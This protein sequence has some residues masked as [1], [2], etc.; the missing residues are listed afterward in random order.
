MVNE[1]ISKKKRIALL[2]TYFV[3]YLFVFQLL[4]EGAV[5]TKFG[6]T[7]LILSDALANAFVLVFFVYL[8]NDWLSKQWQIF[9]QKEQRSLRI[10]VY[11]F[12]A[13]LAVTILFS[14]CIA[15]PLH[16]S[17]AEN[18]V[19]NETMMGF[20]KIGFLFL[21]LM[22]APFVE[23][24]VFRGCIYHP[25]GQKWGMLA[26]ALLSGLIF[27]LLHIGASVSMGNWTNVL[28]IIDYGMCG[29]VLSY[30]FG[31][32]DSIWTSIIVHALFNLFGVLTML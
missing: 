17:E 15:G 20:N 5:Y 11:G 26:G 21:S 13:L 27:G 10:I 31:R 2:L 4:I 28:Y 29:V 14:L 6:S 19:N 18:Q 23:E 9:L 22:I 12:L 3:G 1:V 8:L 7:G 24:I 25:I 16:L 30:V 32:S